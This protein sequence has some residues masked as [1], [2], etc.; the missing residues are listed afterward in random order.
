MVRS[1]IGP[2]RRM[3]T[4]SSA[5]SSKREAQAAPAPRRLDGAIYAFSNLALAEVELEN[6]EKA[7]SM[8]KSLERRSLNSADVRVATPVSQRRYEF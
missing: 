4:R 3:I 5:N 6:E 2:R 8:F 1:V 7:L